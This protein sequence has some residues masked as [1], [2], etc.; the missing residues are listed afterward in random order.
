MRDGQTIQVGNSELMVGDVVI[1]ETGDVIA[2]DG[3]FIS[4]FN[5][6]CDE[7]SLTGESDAAIKGTDTDPFLISGTKVT[8]GVGRMVV[9]ATGEHS[10]NGRIMMNLN[11]EQED[12]PLQ[13]K[14]TDLAD[15]IAKIGVSAAGVMVLILVVAYFSVKT[16]LGV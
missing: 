1:I 6:K 16:E 3:I 11:T 14:L 13:A 7:S 10:L 4:G 12:T 9:V 8:S 5:L 15:T 2:A